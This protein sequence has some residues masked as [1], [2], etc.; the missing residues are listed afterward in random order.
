VFIY[1]RRADKSVRTIVTYPP[2]LV[3]PGW[4]PLKIANIDRLRR[5][6]R[7]EVQPTS[8]RRYV[9]RYDYDD[10]N[11][12]IAVDKPCVRPGNV[13]PDRDVLIASAG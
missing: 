12:R 2:S 5:L 10:Q 1:D 7:L 4:H 6:T 3:E 11:R 9:G 8:D 13:D